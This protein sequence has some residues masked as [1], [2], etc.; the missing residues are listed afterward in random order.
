MHNLRKAAVIKS[1]WEA[2][3]GQ[4]LTPPPCR[5]LAGRLYMLGV[6]VGIMRREG[7]MGFMT[8]LQP[9]QLNVFMQ[10]VHSLLYIFC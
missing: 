10:V 1:A 3:H 7:I 4:V 9:L 8:S 2:R 6:G 5:C